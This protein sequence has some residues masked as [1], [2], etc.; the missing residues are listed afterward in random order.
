MKRSAATDDPSQRDKKLRR[1]SGLEAL[2]LGGATESKDGCK[3][4]EELMATAPLRALPLVLVNSGFLFKHECL[5]AAATCR[6]WRDVWNEVEDKCQSDCLVEISCVKDDQDEWPDWVECS[7]LQ[8]AIPTQAFVRQ[9]F[10]RANDLK[11]AACRTESE[12]REVRDNLPKWG[13]TFHRA[14]VVV[15]DS[16]ILVPGGLAIMLFKYDC[17]SNP[18]STGTWI[19]LDWE[20]TLTEDMEVAMGLGERAQNL[21]DAQGSRPLFDWHFVQFPYEA[22]FRLFIRHAFRTATRP[23]RHVAG[24]NVGPVPALPR[25]EVAGANVGLAPAAMQPPPSPPAAVASD[26]EAEHAHGETGD[27]AET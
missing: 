6:D 7:G 2:T 25:R 20:V 21:Y 15:V 10:N 18:S 1:S 23:R 3:R 9:I 16:T 19:K 11:V 8:T 4:Q 13:V 27:D 5:S 26:A 12:K 24:A 17:D 22:A 14:K